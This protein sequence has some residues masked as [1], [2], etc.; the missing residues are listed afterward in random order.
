MQ[1]QDAMLGTAV[2]FGQTT[3][4]G[5]AGLEKLWTSTPCHSERSCDSERSEESQPVETLRSVALGSGQFQALTDQTPLSAPGGSQ[6]RESSPRLSLDRQ[7][8]CILELARGWRNF[9]CPSIPH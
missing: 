4:F 1:E 7:T 8:C 9:L 2:R 6:Q 3:F 5:R